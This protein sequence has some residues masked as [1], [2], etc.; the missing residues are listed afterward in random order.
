MDDL[1]E[2]Q[3][4]KTLDWIQNAIERH[5]TN[6]D[7]LEI[8]D[9]FYEETDSIVRSFTFSRGQREYL[10]VIGPR[11]HIAGISSKSDSNLMTQIYNVL[12]GLMWQIVN[13]GLAVN[14]PYP[15]PYFNRYS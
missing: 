8:E 2:N 14:K 1:R 7:L 15:L 13:G 10:V 9:I 4:R 5:I 11:F 12:N 6:W 3:Q